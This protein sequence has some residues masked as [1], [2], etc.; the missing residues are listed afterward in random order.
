MIQHIMEPT[1]IL[2]STS[3]I[4]SSNC[5]AWPVLPGARS[6][7]RCA[8]GRA[9]SRT[10]STLVCCS[11]PDHRHNHHA[12]P[13]YL[14][15]AR[16]LTQSCRHLHGSFRRCSRLQNFSPCRRSPITSMR[17]SLRYCFTPS[18]KQLSHPVF[19]PISFQISTRNSAHAHAS[20]GTSMS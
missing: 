5:Q 16:C 15:L 13:S 2:N 19:P 18:F 12:T 4:M 20:I 1:F 11:F 6:C 14:D 8:R 9:S 7:G 17:S 10:T 3:Y